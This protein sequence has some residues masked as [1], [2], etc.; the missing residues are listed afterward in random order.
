MRFESL[1]DKDGSNPRKISA[2]LPNDS[3]FQLTPDLGSC[4]CDRKLSRMNPSSCIFSP[5]IDGFLGG[6]RGLD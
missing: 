2:F 5:L 6:H 4:R 3:S 1:I